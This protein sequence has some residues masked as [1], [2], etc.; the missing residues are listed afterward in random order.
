VP[1]PTLFDAPT[2]NRGLFSDHY[3]N[4]RLTARPDVSDLEAE[5][6]E[7]FEEILQIYRNRAPALEGANEDQTEDQFVRPVLEA[8][9]WHRQV[10]TSSQ[11][12]GQRGQPDYALF[13]SEERRDQAVTDYGPNDERIYGRAQ[14]FAEAKRW[15]RP[16]DRGGKDHLAEEDPLS[17]GT[18]ALQVVGYFVL[19][20][21]DWGVLTNGARWRLYYA[22]S[23]S[24]M[25]TFYEV[26]LEHILRSAEEDEETAREDF[27]RFYAFFRAGAFRPDPSTGETFVEDVLEASDTFGAELEDALKERIFDDVFLNL[28]EGL[29]EDLA[30]EEEDEAAS[31]NLDEIYRATLRLLYRLLFLLYAEARGLLPVQDELGY[32][33]YSLTHLTREIADDV[34]QG[35][36]F[37]RYSDDLWNDLQSLFRI[38]SGGA[39]DLNV[40]RYNGGLFRMGEGD[41]QFLDKRSVSDK[42]LVPALIALTRQ[43]QDP[44]EP[45]VDYKALDVRQLGSIYEGLLEHKLTET[46]D[47]LDLLTGEGERKETGSYYT[48]HYVVEY[49]VE[50][51]VGPVADR[52]IER[53]KTAMEEIREME[54]GDGAPAELEQKRKEARDALLTLRVCD[55]AT[56]SG[57]FLVHATDY[58]ADQFSDVLG[59]YPENPVLERIDEIRSDVLRDLEEQGVEIEDEDRSLGDT[60]LLKRL[61]MKRC[62]YG[63]DLNPLAI[64]LA[65]L[66]LW[67]RS[68]TVGAPL[69]FLDHHL[70]AGN[71]LIGT[72]VKA[73]KDELEADGSQYAMFGGP[74]SGLEEVTE[75]MQEVSRRADATLEEVEES[76][77]RFA[78]YEEEAE[79][80]RRVLDLWTSRHFDN[81][82]AEAI[83]Q[84]F[85][86]QVLDVFRGEAEPQDETQREVL[87]NAEA[88]SREKRFFHW[89]LEFP[90]V[91]YDLSAGAK[92]DDPGFDAVVG[93]P[94]YVRIQTLSETDEAVVRYFNGTYESPSGN[95]DIYQLFVEKGGS[96]LG[97]DGILGYILP[98]KFFTANYGEG[99]RQWV[100]ERRSLQH[101]VY[102]GSDQVF[103]NVTTYTCLLFLSGTSRD[104]FSYLQP[105]R[106]ESIGTEREEDP[107][108][109]QNEAL[110]EKPWSFGNPKLLELRSRLDEEHPSLEEV[111]SRIFQGLKTSADAIYIVNEIERDGNE[112]RIHSP[113]LDEEFRVETDLFHP[114]V[115]GGDINAYHLADTDRLIL[116]PYGP[117]ED[118]EVNLIPAETLEKEYPLTWDYLTRNREYLENREGGAFQDDKWFRFGR[119]Q[120]LDNIQYPKIATP[121]FAPSASYGYDETGESYFTGGTAGGYGILING[122]VSEW[123][124][125]ALLNSRL[126]DRILK[127]VS[128]T[129]R[130]GWCSYESR[131]I[132]HLPIR[133]IEFSTSEKERESHVN[134]L[135]DEYENMGNERGDGVLDDLL[136]TIEDHLG[137]DS[138]R[139]DVVHDFL[140]ELSRRMTAM[141]EERHSIPLDLTDYVGA[142]EDGGGVALT[143]IGTRYQPVPGVGD[144]IVTD[145]TEERDGLRVGRLVS[146]IEGEEGDRDVIISATARY[147]PD[148]DEGFT[149]DDKDQWGFVETDP[150]GVCTL[151]GCTN[152]EAGLVK[153][154]LRA[155]SDRGDGFSG[156]RDNAT[157]TNSLRDRILDIR[158]P[159]PE[160]N[161]ASLRPFLDN[162]KT[163]ADLDRRIRFTDRLID[164]IVY[165]LYGLSDDEVAVVE[166]RS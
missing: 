97:G 79:P 36:T 129:F 88:A 6:E 109:L 112:V 48:P 148:A 133:E 87:Q 119:T 66:S 27:R 33:E 111:T 82:Q 29:Y 96:L 151:V 158:F 73:V 25:D 131:F 22:G 75:L 17:K 106:P 72:S 59:Q 49:I 115:K 50:E 39:P 146:E 8:L 117:D 114:L 7:A 98:H 120:A 12:V 160:A 34:R 134:A 63:V 23:P 71:S 86:E 116:F 159:D 47:G 130:G 164:Q 61:I 31:E 67:L 137:T 135:V 11:N 103:E 149:D 143:G 153:H 161:A 54:G 125:L 85:G 121:D 166:D 122:S 56:G 69:S 76:A 126:L 18:P 41:N 14:I 99:L 100:S 28:A 55:P 74:F 13:T 2:D 77:E 4:E 68:F 127:T 38:I 58:L 84:D 155:L 89:E 91:Y 118:G 104:T 15:G 19:T 32:Y 53:F 70:R 24:R 108:V 64:E 83:L 51:T 110:D 46:E 35:R 139:A 1:A 80:Y 45:R 165:R 157:K 144:S 21:K 163:A 57:H 92:K 95:Y 140:V 43:E 81:D 123:Y 145:S 16:L 5:A 136:G 152:L 128:T 3:L 93:N 40:P 26:N 113:H 44:G 102:F 156:Y 138:G 30:A 20:G 124:M 147:K 37:T 90:E 65:K 94:P 141:K 105:T 78:D 107:F 101:V 142:P 60:A 42:R 150:V 62:M 9:G 10:Q 52:R 132:K 162:A 154:W